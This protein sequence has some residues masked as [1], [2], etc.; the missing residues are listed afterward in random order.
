MHIIYIF[1][2]IIQNKGYAPELALGR[3]GVSKVSDGR[4]RDVL[5]YEDLLLV[6]FD[7]FVVLPLAEGH[8][9]HWLVLYMHAAMMMQYFVLRQ[10]QL[11]KYTTSIKLLS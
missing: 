4:L 3:C 6:L 2:V 7:D 11:L 9:L 1:P 10:Q 8:D 5:L